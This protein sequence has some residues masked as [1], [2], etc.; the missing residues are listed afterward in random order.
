MGKAELKKVL[1]VDDS[2]VVH[3]IF[4]MLLK[5]YPECKKVS[6]FNGEEALNIL[7]KE[8]DFDLI[9]LDLNMPVLDGLTFLSIAKQKKI[10]EKIPVIICSEADENTIKKS[11][12]EGGRALLRKP[13]KNV[14][15]YEL[16]E[17][18]IYGSL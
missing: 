12:E 9:I 7:E 16:V 5:R 3:A 8:D 14:Q 4:E 17:R 2:K 6:A 10:L 11:L 13:F 1:V 18:V 15:F